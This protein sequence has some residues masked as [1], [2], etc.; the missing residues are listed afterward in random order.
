MSSPE[1]IKPNDSGIDLK[2]AKLPS[3]SVYD[4]DDVKATTAPTAAPPAPNT[5]AAAPPADED[6]E[7]AFDP[8]E[9][10]R[11]AIIAT[12]DKIARRKLMMQIQRY[13]G[14]SR[15]G[16]YLTKMKLNDDL[17][18]LTIPEMQTLLGEIKFC[19]QNKTTSDMIQ[20]GVPQ[21]ICAAEP[22]VS[23]FYDVKG[24]SNM[25]GASESFKDI[26]EEVALECQVFSD[27]PASK[28]LMLEVMKTSVFVH[29]A[30]AARAAAAKAV[31][32]KPVT[33]TESSADLMK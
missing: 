16:K 24:L 19:I 8:E 15:F 23:V 17:D 5:A 12:E 29:E 18:Q 30:N 11:H 3:T 4:G 32:E 26:L 25:L 33:L 31:V 6:R 27:T 21:L 13:Y 1:V 20:R 9:E 7:E 28:R 14:S 2:D 22:M 10:R